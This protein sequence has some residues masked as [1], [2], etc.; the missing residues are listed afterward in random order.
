LLHDLSLRL[1]GLLAP[2]RRDEAM[3]VYR[4]SLDVSPRDIGLLQ[5]LLALYR[6]GDDQAE[7]A[8]LLER[9]AAES[10]PA[11]ATRLALQLSDAREALGDEAGVE[12]ALALAFRASPHDDAVRGRLERWYAAREDWPK[13]RE[14]ILYVADAETD[15][16]AAVARYRQGA[17]IAESQLGDSRLAASDLRRARERDASDLGLVRELAMQLEA[18]GDHDAAIAEVTTAI[19]SLDDPRRRAELLRSRAE[20]YARHESDADAVADLELALSLGDS[21]AAPDLAAA[22]EHWLS[23]AYSRGDQA[24]E[25]AATLR[26]AEVLKLAGDVARARELLASWTER[27]PNDQ[28]ALHALADL[29]EAAG[30][31]DAVA[32]TCGRLLHVEQGEAAIATVLRLA[33]ACERAGR[34]EEARPALEHVA[35]QHPESPELRARLRKL[36]EQ[37]GA[38]RELA[39]VILREANES[40]D[41][42]AKLERYKQAGALLLA[43]GDAAAAAPALEAALAI[44]PG[45]HETTVNLTDAYVATARLEQATA[46]VDAAIAAHKGRRSRDLAVLQH[47]M[48]RIA[49]AAGDR[50]VELAWLNVALDAD[51]QN[52]AVASELAEVATTLGQLDVALKALRAVTMMKAPGPMTKAQAYLRQAMIAHHQGDARKAVVLARKAQSEDPHLADAKQFLASLGE[53][54]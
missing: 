2:K 22:L 50:N 3:D 28:E 36:Y 52:G 46:L 12:R 49:F 20:L 38:R 17:A 6:D 11:E 45:D 39:D 43:A 30:A 44:R 23:R 54:V 14:L 10:E 27:A 53:R 5:A 47:R 21:S 15:A 32:Y 37:I 4:A 7:R 1:G 19:E 41:P 8:D 51:M 25:R 31:W 26:L 34:T 29:D 48:A 35:Y 24:A 18:A 40:S 33:D 16:A 42:A 13:L 9:V